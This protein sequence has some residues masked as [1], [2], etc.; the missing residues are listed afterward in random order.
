MPAIF[1]FSSTPLALPRARNTDFSQLFS[2]TPG[3]CRGEFNPERDVLLE[4]ASADFSQQ[5]TVN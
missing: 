1:A 4:R 2:L 5:N 3:D